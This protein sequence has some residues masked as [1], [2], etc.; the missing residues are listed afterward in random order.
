MGGW[1]EVKLSVVNLFLQASFQAS[2]LARVEIDRST[3]M[4]CYKE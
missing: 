1:R 4:I 2:S 3:L